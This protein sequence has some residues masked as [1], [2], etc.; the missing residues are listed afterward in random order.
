MLELAFQLVDQNSREIKE[1][2]LNELICNQAFWSYEK[3]EMNTISDNQLIEK[4]LI[5]SDLDSI[6]QL[7]SI[8]SESQIRRVWDERLLPDVRFYS[9]NKLFAYLLFHIENPDDYLESGIRNHYK[10]LSA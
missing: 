3:P 8:Y 6:Y 4:V 2:L 1:G 9:M 7:F 5:H 10:K